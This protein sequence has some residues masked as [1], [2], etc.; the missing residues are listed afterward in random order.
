MNDSDSTGLRYIPLAPQYIDEIM[1]IE[2]EAYAEPWT[3]AM[4][5]EEMRN[6]QSRFYVALEGDAL[7]GYGGFWLVANEAHITSVTI[8]DMY[9]GRGF[10]RQ[11]AEYILERAIEESACLATLEV[12]ASNTRALNL[13]KSLGFRP[14]GLRKAY[15]P[16][17]DE[18][19]IVMT[20]ALE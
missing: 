10:G 2:L 20:K 11:L 3:R 6:K 4:F 17:S 12:R 19:A 13:Y 15:Y 5:Q 18:D 8:R 1:A 14:V 16:K 9:R 7:V